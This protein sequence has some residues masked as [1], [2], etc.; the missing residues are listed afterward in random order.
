MEPSWLKMVLTA[1]GIAAAL[2]TVVGV[3]VGSMPED[4]DAARRTQLKTL[5]AVVESDGDLVRGKGVTEISHQASTGEYEVKFNRN[6]DGCAYSATFD[7]SSEFIFISLRDASIG[8]REVGV[9]TTDRGAF[10]RDSP[11]HLIV[12]C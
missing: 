12:N 6:V 4:A 11:F 5:W 3:V 8:T 2:L 1:A 9:T 10:V 7:H